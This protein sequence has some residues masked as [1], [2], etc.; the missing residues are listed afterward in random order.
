[1]GFYGALAAMPSGDQVFYGN[2]SS[3][4]IRA[5]FTNNTCV[6]VGGSP[7]HTVTVDQNLNVW[8]AF[9]SGA[10]VAKWSPQ[11]VQ[12]GQYPITGVAH[13]VSVA[14]DGFIWANGYSSNYFCMKV[15]QNTGALVGAYRYDCPNC[16]NPAN[17][18]Y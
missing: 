18:N 8:G 17:I 14:F 4:L 13:G 3:G 5:D 10:Y 15:N 16:P 2:T 1:P 6:T 9:A 11:G 7:I 12:L